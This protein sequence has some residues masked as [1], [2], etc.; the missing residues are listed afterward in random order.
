MTSLSLVLVPFV[1]L[2]ASVLIAFFVEPSFSARDLSI[3]KVLDMMVDIDTL[4]HYADH[5]EYDKSNSN[6]SIYRGYENQGNQG[7]LKRRQPK[8][9]KR[10]RTIQRRGSQEVLDGAVEQARGAVQSAIDTPPG[11]NYAALEATLKPLAESNADL[12][13]ILATGPITSG[14]L[15]A[16]L[17]ALPDA[18]NSQ[19]RRSEAAAQRVAMNVAHKAENWEGY[20]SSVSLVPLAV[21]RDFGQEW[22]AVNLRQRKTKTFSTSI[23][24]FEGVAQW[25][26]ILFGAHVLAGDHGLHEGPFLVAKG[27]VAVDGEFQEAFTAVEQAINAINK[28][29]TNKLQ[30]AKK[31]L[32]TK[33]VGLKDRDSGLS[34]ILAGY[35]HWEENAFTHAATLNDLIEFRNLFQAAL[36]C[37]VKAWLSGN[38]IEVEVRGRR[39]DVVHGVWEATKKALGA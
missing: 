36:T 3:Q 14:N 7:G 6:P 33:L 20:A 10:R 31:T 29:S 27:Q 9:R 16:L 30:N 22:E 28:A 24:S 23:I 37:Y 25:L 12:A 17:S 34:E 4:G 26:K 19:A 13:E 5:T 21:T 1:L 11:D 8:G 15:E 18:G 38:D 32:Q 39:A 35:K 2:G